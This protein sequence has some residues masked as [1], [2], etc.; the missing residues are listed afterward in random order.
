MHKLRDPETEVDIVP[1]ITNTL[2]SI[3]KLVEGGYFAVYDEN[4][5]NIYDGKKAKILITEEAFTMEDTAS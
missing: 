4:E 1:G 5:V 3:G 2:L